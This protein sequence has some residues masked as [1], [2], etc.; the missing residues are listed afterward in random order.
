MYIYLNKLGQSYQ[1]KKKH[2]IL[3]VS[4]LSRLLHKRETGAKTTQ[5]P[6]HAREALPLLT[7]TPAKQKQGAYRTPNFQLPYRTQTSLSPSV[8]NS[9]LSLPFPQSPL[10]QLVF[11]RS[12]YYIAQRGPALQS[13][14]RAHPGERDMQSTRVPIGPS[15]SV[16]Y[17]LWERCDTALRG[18]GDQTSSSTPSM[19]VPACAAIPHGK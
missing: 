14:C 11:H 16:P 6:W 10:A 2:R 15:F 9:K 12:D 5:T 18:G 13:H 4:P 19:H 8:C 17:Q 7:P 1:L 3:I